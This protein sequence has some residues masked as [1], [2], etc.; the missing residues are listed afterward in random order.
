[1]SDRLHQRLGGHLRRHSVAYASEVRLF[2]TVS[3]STQSVP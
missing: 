1:M 3:T 2:R